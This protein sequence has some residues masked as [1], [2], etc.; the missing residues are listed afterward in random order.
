MKTKILCIV[1]IFLLFSCSPKQ[2]NPYKPPDLNLKPTPAF[3]IK[4][5]LNSIPK[6]SKIIPMYV[7]EI[8]ESNYVI[9]ENSGEATH[10][11][12]TPLEYA[13]IGAVIR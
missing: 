11:L 13:K 1:L 8:D 6:P 10:I 2:F 3:D 9:V 5:D 4:E 12:L 7:K